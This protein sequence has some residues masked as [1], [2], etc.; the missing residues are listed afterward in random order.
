MSKKNKKVTFVFQTGRAKKIESEIPYAKDM[1]YTYFNF[2]KEYETDIIEFRHFEHTIINKFFLVFEREVIRRFFKIPVYWVF[3][4]SKENFKKLF[5]SNAIILSTNRVASSVLPMLIIIKLL[6]R[7]VSVSFFVLGLYSSEP[8]YIFLKFFQSLYYFVL[9]LVADNIFFI[10]EGEYE[11]AIKKKRF[12]LN[13]FH[14]IPFGIDL[15]FWKTNK[16]ININEK[17][18]ILFVGNDSNRN[19]KTVIELSKKLKKYDFTFVTNQISQEEIPENV[20]LHK[21]SWGTP[22]VT[23]TEL[24]K[25]YE[26][27]KL[28]IIPLKESLQPSGQ[29]VALQSMAVGTPVLITK[30]SGLWDKKNIIDEENIFLLESDNLDEWKEKI[31]NLYENTEKLNKISKNSIRCIDDHFDKE[32]FY[33]NIKSKIK[34]L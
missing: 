20:V 26:K 22:A 16:Q 21:G 9:F 18:G 17:S 32:Q 14:Y 5:N 29:S 12:F 27:N 25:L 10:G 34:I 23:D 2:Q 11:Y 3:L 33:I 24:K 31:L 19:F 7:K 1:F 8:K 4:T 6:K 15:D 30:T 28:T 13:K